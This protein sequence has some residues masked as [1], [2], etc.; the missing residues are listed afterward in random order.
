MKVV[1]PASLAFLLS[2]SSAFVISSLG[3]HQPSSLQVATEDVSTSTK[4]IPPRS[5]DDLLS[6]VGE[7]GQLYDQNVQKTYG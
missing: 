3:V 2:Y 5:I 1:L 7:T 4:L 6:H